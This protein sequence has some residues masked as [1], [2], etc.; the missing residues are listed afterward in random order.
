MGLV[1]TGLRKQLCVGVFGKGQTRTAYS[2]SEPIEEIKSNGKK[3]GE[4][5]K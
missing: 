5:L 3:I 1:V 4:I 2:R